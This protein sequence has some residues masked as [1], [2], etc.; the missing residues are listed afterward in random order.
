[1][2]TAC[3]SLA[4][5][6]EEMQHTSQENDDELVRAFGR[7]PPRYLY[8]YLPA[9]DPQKVDWALELIQMQRLHLSSV[10]DFNDP[11]DCLPAIQVPSPAALKL[12]LRRDRKRVMHLGPKEVGD[13]TLVRLSRQPPSRIR[14]F[15]EDTF[16]A[17]IGQMG[18]A[19]FS[20]RHDD[21]GMWSH[22][23]NAHKGI[24]VRFDTALWPV[25]HP[26]TMLLPV[27]YSAERSP[28]HFPSH[29]RVTRVTEMFGVLTRKATLWSAEKEWRLLVGDG[30]G[31]KIDFPKQ[32][33]D[34]VILGAHANDSLAETLGAL[35]S[36][37]LSIYRACI[38]SSSFSLGFERLGQHP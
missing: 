13:A 21:I 30:A 7:P 20:E 29:P 2:Q 37:K 17:T 27:T 6:K 9:S 5:Q 8:R 15:A 3:S 24:C 22:Y 32:L 4:P 14:Q 16:R 18:V 10:L 34:R 1:M 12:R 35:Q 38:D 23:A 36:A 28:L 11:F 31:S 19:C 25:G 26:F 33:I